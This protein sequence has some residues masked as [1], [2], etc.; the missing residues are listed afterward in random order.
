MET[1]MSSESE[2]RSQRT[3]LFVR[4]LFSELFADNGQ[5]FEELIA[6]SR[7]EEDSFRIRRKPAIDPAFTT[8]RRP[9]IQFSKTTRRPTTTRPIT[10]PGPKFR[11]VFRAKNREEEPFEV[12]DKHVDV[13]RE[14]AIAAPPHPVFLPR[15][16]STNTAVAPQLP[17][18]S[19]LPTA[20]RTAPPFR[21]AVQ[22]TTQRFLKF[23]FYKRIRGHLGPVDIHNLSDDNTFDLMMFLFG[24]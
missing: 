19:A 16:S 14:I 2:P 13:V 4:K 18:P 9:Q 17:T 5:S 11:P 24:F 20:T 8:T 23:I 12:S 22:H 7:T 1:R 3:L 15:T 6:C 21:N 10:V